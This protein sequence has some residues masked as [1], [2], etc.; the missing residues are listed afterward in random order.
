MASQN[1]IVGIAANANDGDTL[2]AAFIKVK[3]MFAEVYG[4]NYSE[5][6]DLS[7]T[8][9]KI[10][11]SRMETTNTA[12]SS[13][14]G[15]VMTY[16]H[17]TGGFTFKEYFNG[18]ITRVQG[19]SGL[20]GDTQSGNATINIDLN[21]LT[22]AALDVANDDIAFVDTSDTNATRKESIADLVTAIAGSGLTATNG[23]LSSSGGGVSANSVDH[24]E[25][26]ERYTAIV[27]KNDTSGTGASAIDIGWDD[28]TVF[29]FTATLTGAIELKFDAYK[30]G[31]VI[32]IY[33]L[34]GSQTITFT[35]TG[36]GTT[37]VNNVG[38]GEYDGSATN[39][40]Q[41]VCL[42]EGNSPTF[43]YST[44]TYTSDNSPNA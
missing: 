27:S 32:D 7:G 20:S 25:L 41:I 34:T 36:T 3:K 19:G 15:Y 9:F 31:Q 40:I 8:D 16:D 38:A 22:E 1:L 12:A 17:S 39:H 5:Q 11:A 10:D 43:N 26:A 21:D 35:S 28:G 23:V 2:R 30:V 33:G 14:D 37:T 24:D 29:N 6:G 13:R 18:D 44:A 4:Q 42:A